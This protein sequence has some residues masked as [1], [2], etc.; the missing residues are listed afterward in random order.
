MPGTVLKSHLYPQRALLQNLALPNGT[1]LTRL[2]WEDNCYGLE[3]I[4]AI[5]DA[6][7]LPVPSSIS[8]RLGD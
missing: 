7:G 5:L 6:E 2:E 1:K 8:C 3:G 4:Q